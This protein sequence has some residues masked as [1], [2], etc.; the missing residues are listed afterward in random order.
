MPR[1]KPPYPTAFRTEAVR[2]VHSSGKSI[3]VIA[4]D[5]G[6]SDQAVRGWVRQAEI[7]TGQRAGLTSGE[8][9]ELR[10][11]RRENR[12]P[13][14]ERDILKKAAAFFARESSAIR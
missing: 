5:L 12:I 2:L 3:P 11:L 14:E 13:K 10:Q 6:V 4:N 7:D 9:E 8:H 1:T